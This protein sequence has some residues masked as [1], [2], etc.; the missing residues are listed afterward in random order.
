MRLDVGGEFLVEG[1][2]RSQLGRSMIL[3]TALPTDVAQVGSVF[4]SNESRSRRLCDA[5]VT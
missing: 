5:L 3:S 4:A 2:V 1:Q